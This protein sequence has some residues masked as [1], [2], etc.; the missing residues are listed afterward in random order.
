MAHLLWVIVVARHVCGISLSEYEVIYAAFFMFHHDRSM[1]RLN[2]HDIL[3]DH[4]HSGKHGSDECVL[5]I[6]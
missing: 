3:N 2:A 1:G 5:N 4:Y 6:G